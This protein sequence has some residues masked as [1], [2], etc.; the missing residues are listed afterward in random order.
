MVK[1]KLICFAGGGSG[2]HVIPGTVIARKFLK[3]GYSI[4]WIGSKKTRQLE[5]SILENEFSSWENLSNSASLEKGKKKE[6][7]SGY[8]YLSIS[9][10]KFR[11]KSS[12]IGSIFSIKN[13]I[14]IINIFL[15]CLESLFILIRYKPALIFSKGGF[16]SVPVLVAARILSIKRYTH[17]SDHSLG[18]ANKIN[19]K[20]SQKIF[21]S[22]PNP[23]ESILK[24]RGIYSSNP[25]R[26]K[27][28][29]ISLE[30][31][32]TPFSFPLHKPVLLILGGSLGA[33]NLNRIIYDNLAFLEEHFNIIHQ[34]GK[35]K[36]KIKANDFYKPVEFI[37]NDI[38][39]IMAGA[40]LIISRSGANLV[41]EIMAL[42]KPAIFVPLEGG[43]RGEQMGN[44]LFF[45]QQGMCRVYE[46]SQFE[47]DFI[48]VMDSIIKSGEIK[49][50]SEKLEKLSLPDAGELIYTYL[51]KLIV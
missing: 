39:K 13:L 31:F 12:L 7:E 40:D 28:K 34:C 4:L 22:Y 45:E 18:L 33:E 17:E 49:N 51:K 44:A 6:T 38:E 16:V 27:F 11:R 37:F 50:L 9:S 41:F 25:V 46:E 32:K 2:G 23:S 36:I 19:A 30:N 43:S 15:G 21:Y 20:L 35:N 14:D 42:K 3:D 26:D 29:N 8:N 48:S 10:G 1:N 5:K 24:S 47:S